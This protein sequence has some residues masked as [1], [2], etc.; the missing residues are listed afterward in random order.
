MLDCCG[1]LQKGWVS[2]DSFDIGRF[3]IYLLVFVYCLIELVQKVATLID[4]KSMWD[5]VIGRD[6]T[7]LDVIRR[8]FWLLY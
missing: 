5:Y 4:T 6:S 2:R 8:N 1:F 7:Q 3:V